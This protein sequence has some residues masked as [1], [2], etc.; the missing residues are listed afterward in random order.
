MDKPTENTTEVKADI[1]YKQ[2]LERLDGFKKEIDELH[3][4][5][6]SVCQFNKELLSR[7]TPI[8]PTSSEAES[9]LKAYLNE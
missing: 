2:L 7:S 1:T 8:T 6:N 3:S 4:T 5:I 9:K